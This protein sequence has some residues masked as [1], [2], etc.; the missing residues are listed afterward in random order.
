MSFHPAPAAHSG[1][2]VLVPDLDGALTRPLE[3]LADLLTDLRAWIAQPDGGRRPDLPG[4]LADCSTLLSVRRL[5][6]LLEP[7]QR[8]SAR[9]PE[10]YGPHAPE[11]HVVLTPVRLPGPDVGALSLSARVLGHPAL[12]AP[13]RDL[14]TIYAGVGLPDDLPA[15]PRELVAELAGLVGL[16]DLP[17]TPGTRLLAARLLSAQRR[18]QPAVLTAEEEVAYQDI[19]EQIN[20][21]WTASSRDHRPL[22]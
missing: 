17:A 12:P 11:P 13:V 14:L 9:R 4:I 20:L 16:L 1:L 19:L 3:L 6:Y 10:V 22:R 18:G 7:T 15:D 21:L 5:L 8:C 2:G